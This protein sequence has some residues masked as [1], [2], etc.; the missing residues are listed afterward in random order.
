MDDVASLAGAGKDIVLVSSGAI[1]LGRHALKLP[2]RPLALEESQAAAAVGQIS[3]AHAY[4]ELARERGLTAAQILL[5]RGD[6]EE[7]RPYLNAR[8]TLEQLLALAR[9]PSSTRTTRLQRAK[10]ATAT[11]IGSPRRH[12]RDGTLRLELAADPARKTDRPSPAA[13]RRSTNICASKRAKTS[14]GRSRSATSPSKRER[15]AWLAT[16][17]SRRPPSP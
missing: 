7:R 14:N 13:R 4:Q 12:R 8:H 6:T 15:G 1:A 17:R 10:S 16:T 3:L 2:N 5:T 11:T 9:F